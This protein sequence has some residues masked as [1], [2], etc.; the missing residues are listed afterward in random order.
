MATISANNIESVERILGSLNL[1]LFNSIKFI[2]S[3]K[4]VL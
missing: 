2:T 1:K 4:K 3:E